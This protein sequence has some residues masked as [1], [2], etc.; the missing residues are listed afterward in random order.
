MAA[1]QNTL[2]AK[3]CDNATSGG[4]SIRKLHDGAGLYLWVYED[5]RKYWR[6]RY[7]MAGK[8]KSLSLGVYPEIGLKEAR[9][10]RDDNRRL[11]G[12]SIDPSAE[13]KAGK[14]RQLRASE[15]SFEAV[16][17]EW[18]AKQLHTWVPKH[19]ND[20]LRRFE[21]NTFPFIGARPIGE[22]EAPELLEM[23]RKIEKRGA[24]DLAHR[25]MQACGQV[26]R[27]GIATGRCKRDVAADLRGALT[28]HIKKHQAAVRPEDVPTL[29]RAIDTY[30]E[31]G[32]KQT[33]HALQLLA[34]TFVRTNELIGAEWS[35]FNQEAALWVIPAARMKMKSEHIVPLSAQALAILS[36]LQVLA[37]RSRFVFPGRNRDKP[38]SNNTMLFALYRLGYKGKMTGHGFRAVASTMLNEQG[39]R[40]DV[41]ERQLAHCE[42]DEVRGAY[43]R[44]EYLAERVKMMQQWADYLDKIKA[45]AQVIPLHGHAA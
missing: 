1:K 42:R 30:A 4:K 31:Q 33:M 27:Y 17:R 44:A 28:P 18:Y 39:Y 13:R 29:L 26:F 24:H 38:I 7:W 6:L 32:D 22:I 12:E 14:L 8:E 16:A 20:V 3:E 34:L 11:M 40:P 37:G 10:R 2:T 41:I 21:V 36:E 23:S 9:Q 15:N 25:L 43:N 5:G 45:G 19:A 35:E